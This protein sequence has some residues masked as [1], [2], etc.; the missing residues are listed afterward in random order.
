MGVFVVLVAPLL[1]VAMLAACQTASPPASGRRVPQDP[2]VGRARAGLAR[3]QKAL[4]GE[5]GAAMK[6]GGVPAAIS[7]CAERAAEVARALNQQD[8]S[9]RVGRTSDKLRNPKN[10]APSWVVP[11]LA[12]YAAP[13][14]HPRQAQVVALAG[15]QLG[16]VQ[17]LYVGGFCLKC[18]GKAVAPAH[19]ALIDRL[20]PGDRA[21]GY[22]AGQFRGLLWAEVKR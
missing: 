6:S 19:R 12:S 11:L 4:K 9:L 13:G 3:L 15:G 8:P 20:Y 21:S 2:R 10:T 7:V 18:H 5:L 16:Y 1:G 14:A 17:P 22:G